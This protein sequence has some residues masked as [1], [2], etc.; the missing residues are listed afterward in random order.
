VCTLA[1]LSGLGMTLLLLAMY[2]QAL[3]ALPISILL[4]VLF[5]VITRFCIEPAIEAMY[6]SR[7]Y[8]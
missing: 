8:A 1:V 7:V 2:G 4:G 5:Y 6:I 3:P